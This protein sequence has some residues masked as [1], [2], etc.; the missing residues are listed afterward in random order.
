MP[1]WDAV[2]A[3]FVI[4]LVVVAVYVSGLVVHRKRSA[5]RRDVPPEEVRW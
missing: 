3:A 1:V 4:V 2:T 5:S